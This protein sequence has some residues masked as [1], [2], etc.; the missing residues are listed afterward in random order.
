VGLEG[1]AQRYPHQLSGG[2]QQRVAIARAL[3]PDPVL[4]LL[5]EPLSNLDVQVRQHLRQELRDILKTTGTAA[6]FVTHDQEEAL[7]IADQV[8]VMRDGCLEQWGPPEIVYQHPASRFVADFVTHANFLPAQHQHP[9][10]E[11]A[12]G[13]FELPPQAILNANNGNGA[14]RGELMIRQEALELVPDDQGPVM[15]RDRQF[16]G[17]EYRYYLQTLDN[18]TLLARTSADC[19]LAIGQSVRVIVNPG[20]LRLFPAPTPHK[21]DIDTPRPEGRGFFLQRSDLLKLARRPTE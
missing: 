4:V 1:L 13:Y 17:R 21:Q 14:S 5:D 8:A 11:T 18:H 7:A 9:G 16:L 12:I 20:T 3:A 2:Q 10:W 19:A 15:I 6:V